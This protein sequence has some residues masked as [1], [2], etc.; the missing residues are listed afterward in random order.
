MGRGQDRGLGIDWTF[1]LQ[2]G[3][4]DNRGED[5]IHEIG[6]RCPCNNDDTYAGFT[7]QG[8]HVPRKRRLVG[9]QLCN[10]E[11]YI[12]RKSKKVVGLITSIR[13]TKTQ[14]EGGWAVPGD[15]ILSVKPGVAISGGDLI[16]FSWPMPVPDGQVVYR[17]AGNLNDNMARKLGLEEDEDRLWYNAHSSLHCEDEDGIEYSSDG[18]FTLDTSKII[19]WHGNRPQKGKIYTIKYNAYLEWIAFLPPEIRRD[20]GRDLGTRVGL[21]KRHVANANSNFSLSASDRV[22]FCDRMKGC[23]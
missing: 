7:E 4:I 1:P 10:G 6:L 5:L 2:K 17:G 22:L 16:I 13:E 9:C 11:G 15:S 12:Y 18:D 3:F 23:S 20:R 21:R 8:A 14:M 19:K